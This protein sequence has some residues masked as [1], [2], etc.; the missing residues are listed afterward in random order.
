MVVVQ[1]LLVDNFEG[2]KII[3][4]L[5]MDISFIDSVYYYYREAVLLVVI[6]Q[7]DVTYQAILHL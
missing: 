3:G 2:T 5:Q 1:C 4:K 7:V 6:V